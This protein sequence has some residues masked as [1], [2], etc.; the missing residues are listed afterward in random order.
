[1]ETK[2]K[3]PHA[4]WLWALI[5]TAAALMLVALA[6]GLGSGTQPT[7]QEKT[8]VASGCELV[9]T[10]HYS[11]CG[12]D[13]TRRRKAEKELE[14]AELKQV[15]EAFAD[16]TITSY[17]P[18]EI[19]MSCSKA[20]YCPDH[21]VVMPDGAGVLG[22]YFNEYGDGYALQKQLE[23][24]VSDLDEQT[25]ETIHLGLAFKTMQEI[26]LWLE[27]QES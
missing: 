10:I 3:S 8:S 16:W 2:Q 20:L 19:V 7:A 17:A 25:M 27:T 21:L 12:H 9:Q 22:V 11:R 26:E 6:V 4:F 23:V 15:R 1:M 18:H 5:I 14:G 24:P 13:V